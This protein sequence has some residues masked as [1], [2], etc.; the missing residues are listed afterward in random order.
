MES[1]EAEEYVE[2]V[3][4][5]VERVPAG[6]VT[7]YGA[8]ADAVGVGGPRQVGRVMATYGGSVPWW[9]VVRA[10]G[11]LPPCHDGEARER[12]LEEGTAFRAS[13]RVDLTQAMWLPCD[14]AVRIG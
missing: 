7:T 5:L 14:A 12:H 2:S 8:L 6:R 11:T 13:G 3:L 10:D 9:R 4:S 1:Q